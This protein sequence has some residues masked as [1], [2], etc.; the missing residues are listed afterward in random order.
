[1]ARAKWKGPYIDIES[2]NSIVSRNSKIIPKFLGL[3]FKVHNGKS[4]QEITVTEDMLDHKFG[5]FSFTRKKFS[6]KKDK[7]KK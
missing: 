4:Y 6:F 2:N 7:L 3:T 1:M 5:E